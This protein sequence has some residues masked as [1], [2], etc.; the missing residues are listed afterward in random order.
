MRGRGYA[1]D[2]EETEVG[3]RSVA[4]PIRDHRGEVVAA[5]S[6]AGPTQRVSKKVLHSYLPD[7]C[8]AATAISQRLGYQSA[9]GV[10]IAAH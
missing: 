10:P 5:I 2:D 1:I 8:A 6:I 4:A 7:V 3:L 9:A